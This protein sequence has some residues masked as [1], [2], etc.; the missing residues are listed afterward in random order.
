[1]RKINYILTLL[2][3]V[4]GANWAKADDQSLA[5]GNYDTVEY[6]DNPQVYSSSWWMVAP[7]QFNVKY[8]GS[9]IIYTK[10]Q[11]AAMKGKEIKSI[12]FK[13]YNQSAFSAYPKTINVWM[14]ENR[15]CCICL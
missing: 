2:L 15:R 9:Q 3:L 4:I 13:Y 1:M 8:S 11:L 14:K 12:S 7:V 5:L 6:T 10:E